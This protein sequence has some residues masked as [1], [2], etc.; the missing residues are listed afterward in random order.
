MKLPSARTRK[1][2][3]RI[4]RFG[5]LKQTDHAANKISDFPPVCIQRRSFSNGDLFKRIVFLA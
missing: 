3:K 2:S 4:Y 5:I 1:M